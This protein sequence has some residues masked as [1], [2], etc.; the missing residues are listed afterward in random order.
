MSRFVRIFVLVAAITTTGLSSASAQEATEPVLSSP[1]TVDIVILGGTNTV[2]PLVEAHLQSCTDGS[3]TR[4]AGPNRFATAAA[5]SRASFPGG[6]P[7][8]YLSIGTNYPDG[9]A[10]GAVAAAKNA[11]LLLTSGTSLS[12][13]TATELARLGATEVMILGGEKAISVGV[14]AQLA[15]SYTVGR[16]SGPNRYATAA[17]VSASAFPGPVDVVYVATGEDFPDALVGGPAAYAHGSPI[18]LTAPTALSPETALELERLQPGQ[19]IILGGPAVVSSS[20]EGALEAYGPVSR[21]AGSDR[22]STAAAIARTLPPG[23]T[24]LYVTTGSNFPDALAGTPMA[25]A[26]PMLLTSA[27]GMS[28]ATAA[29][30]SSFTGKPCT[31]IVKVSEYTTYYK[32]GQARVTNI[33]TIARAAHGAMV[34]PGETFSLNGHVGRRTLAKGYVAAPAIINGEIY[35][36]DSPINVG[37]GTSQFATTLYNAIFFGGY[38]DVYHKPHSI[39]F[40]HYPLGREATLGWTGPDV[41]FRNDTSTLVTI[42]TRHT[43][44]SVTVEFWG[45]ND[46]RRVSAGLSGS[47]TTNDG[48]RVRVDRTIRFTD[49]TSK[50]QSWWWSYNPLHPDRR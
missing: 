9:V 50:T 19:I 14:E 10:A 36:C 12:P 41:K 27:Y 35:C 37:G 5:I 20:V 31:P 23:A 13:E 7:L 42:R 47:A 40:S 25:K 48:G 11:P 21:I 33:H 28:A 38:E 18:L 43:A 1:S 6:S 2:I 15:A 34:S 24:T 8:A 32:A 39:W 29:A 3:V 16:L 26:N 30:I 44:T 46:G 49:G 4:I 45:W 22:A 17:A